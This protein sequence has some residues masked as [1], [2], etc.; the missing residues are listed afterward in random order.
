MIM[1]RGAPYWAVNF[2]VWVRKPGPMAEVAIKK[3]APN[4]TE[5]LGL[6]AGRSRVT[7]AVLLLI[8]IPPKM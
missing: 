7:L 4:R 8:T 3:A 6:L 5:R 1:I 2:E